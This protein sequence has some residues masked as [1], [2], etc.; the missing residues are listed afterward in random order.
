MTIAARFG[1]AVV[2]A[3]GLVLRPWHPNEIAW[4][5]QACQDPE[6]QRWTTVPSPYTARDALGFLA[7]ASGALAT[8]EAAH[9]AVAD[10]D[11]GWLHGAVAVMVRTDRQAEVGSWVAAESRGRG[12]ATT[13]VRAA[14][15]WALGPLG[16]T[17]VTAEVM[18]GNE[19]SRRLLLACGF[20]QLPGTWP[21]RS[22]AGPV[23]GW[24][25]V[26]SAPGA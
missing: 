2:P 22:R 19:A 17:E 3:G 15:G 6:V 25:F 23:A 9:L 11:S 5:H 1:A 16:F 7:L 21:C 20:T 14:V 8:G 4:I 24:R 10:A 13:A 18:E 12:I 26:L